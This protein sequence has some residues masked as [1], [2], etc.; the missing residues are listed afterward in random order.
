[1]KPLTKY[2]IVK[3]ENKEVKSESGLIIS[4]KPKVELKG[5]VLDVGELVTNITPGDV[6]HFTEV[7]HAGSVEGHEIFVVNSEKVFAIS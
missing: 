7:V 4:S 2:I 3:Q 1:M 6:A 5:I